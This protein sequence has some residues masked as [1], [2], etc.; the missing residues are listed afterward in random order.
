V[1]RSRHCNAR[2]RN[3]IRQWP[4][5]RSQSNTAPS[6]SLQVSGLVCIRLRRAPHPS[7]WFPSPHGVSQRAGLGTEDGT[8]ERWHQPIPGRPRPRARAVRHQAALPDLR[9]YALRPAPSSLYP[10][11]GARSQ[12]SDE[13]IVPL[14]GPRPERPHWCEPIRRREQQCPPD[15]SCRRACRS[16]RRAFSANC[17]ALL[18]K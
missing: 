11:T 2:S 10:I 3:S 14:S 7:Q 6:G 15:K 9:S 5:R 16:G 13:F 8:L 1:S 12:V 18:T 17:S 4:K